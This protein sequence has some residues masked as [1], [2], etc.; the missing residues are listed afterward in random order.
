M[1]SSYDKIIYMASNNY[2]RYQIRKNYD[3]SKL[4]HK[5]LSIL[6]LPI[7]GSDAYSLYNYLEQEADYS[8]IKS[9]ELKDLMSRLNISGAKF[10]SAREALEASKLMK[11]YKTSYDTHDEYIF[12]LF[13][14]Q[15][16]KRFFASGSL[17]LSLLVKKITMTELNR[18]KLT[19][20]IGEK[21]SEQFK[22]ISVSFSDVFEIDDNFFVEHNENF[23]Y[24][25]RDEEEN[26]FE[27]ATF[28]SKLNEVYPD[29]YIL[30]SESSFDKSCINLLSLSMELYNLDYNTLVRLYHDSNTIGNVFSEETFKKKLHNILPSL[31]SV[32][33]EENHEYASYLGDSDTAKKIKAFTKLPPDVVLK[34][35][36]KSKLYASDYDLIEELARDFELSPSV[37]CVLIDRTLYY[38]QGT[39]SRKYILK[40]ARSLV[41][42]SIK[43]DPYEAFYFFYHKD[44]E[45]QG[46]MKKE[47]EI[48]LKETSDG[49]KLGKAE[50][51][52]DTEA[53]DEFEVL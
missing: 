20:K 33:L 39:L 3:L 4:D 37:I 5:V 16:P 30:F 1:F 21:I 29:E 48:N 12:Q 41:F 24:I 47:K 32:I 15:D 13:L 36:V 28:I 8:L 9:N 43:L 7:I 31:E 17:L 46:K 23:E 45:I 49:N 40:L 11:T 52:I 53:F 27:L 2:D 26:R 6:Y 18:L 35:L 42:N 38:T 19:F 25:S 34:H 10:I 51:E 22:D 44:K 14:P 50:K